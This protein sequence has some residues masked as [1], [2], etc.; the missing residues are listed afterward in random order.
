MSEQA[1][2]VLGRTMV[3]LSIVGPF[4]WLGIEHNFPLRLFVI[5]PLGLLAGAVVLG[6]LNHIA[7]EVTK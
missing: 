2:R 4:S 3:L 7:H 6:A 1:K 5:Y